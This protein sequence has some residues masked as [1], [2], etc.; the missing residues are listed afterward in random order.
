MALCKEKVEA[1]WK[2][3][4]ANNDGVLSA[5][6]VK[7]ALQSAEGCKMSAENVEVSVLV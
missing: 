7:A 4:D 3:H 5:D 6:E 1:F 2:A